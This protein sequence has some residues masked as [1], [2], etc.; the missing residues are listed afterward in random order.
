MDN[1]ERQLLGLSTLL[2]LEKNIR[3]ASTQDEFNFIVVNET[4][5]LFQYHQAV[6]WKHRASGKSKITAVSGLADIDVNSPYINWLSDIFNYLLQHGSPK[7]TRMISVD[8]LPAGLHRGWSEWSPAYCLWCPLVSPSGEFLG[9]IWLTRDRHWD[10]NEISL[11]ER[12]TDAY[13][14]AWTTLI[15]HESSWEKKV[16]ASL[17]SKKIRLA[18]LLALVIILVLPIRQSVLAPAEIVAYKPLVVSAPVDGIIK[19]FHIQPNTQVKKGQLLFSLDD[20]ALRNRY[21][22][23]KKSLDVARANFLQVSQK[24]FSNEKSKGE[25]ALLKARVD[26]KTAEVNY[27]AELLE[28]IDVRAENDGVA[29]FT[30]INDW[31]GQPVQIGQKVLFLADSENT[32]LQIWLPVDDAINL[33]PGSEVRVFLNIDPTNPLQAKIRQTSYEAQLKED[34]LLA[35]LL[36]AEFVNTDNKPRIGHK[37]TAKLYGRK[38]SLFYYLMRRPISAIRQLLGL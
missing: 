10:D 34:R 13:A 38:V 32:E 9:G 21:E 8:D 6:L 4:Q 30:D 17:V 11:L 37:G 24:A 27:T 2:Q 23:A 29:V 14:H 35:F 1:T 18:T 28:R 12:L 26:Q 22:I 33:E 3:H 25:L 16:I 19:Q 15:G 20:T 36:K 5:Q 31:I 7:K